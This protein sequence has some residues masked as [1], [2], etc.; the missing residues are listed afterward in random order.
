MSKKF[1]HDIYEEQFSP[2]KIQD[3]LAGR[4]SSQEMHHMEALMQENP[5]LADAIEGLAM[6]PKNENLTNTLAD[7][8][9][10]MPYRK[11]GIKKLDMTH[12]KSWVK[13]S[14]AASVLLVLGITTIFL[15][16]TIDSSMNPKMAESAQSVAY[17]ADS[18]TMPTAKTT[19]A[20][21][22]TPPTKDI[23]Q[24]SAAVAQPKPLE[25]KPQKIKDE[26]TPLPTKKAMESA[27]SP[28]V[29]SAVTTSKYEGEEAEKIAT[30]RQTI[31]EKTDKKE[32][33]KADFEAAKSKRAINQEDLAKPPTVNPVPVGGWAN[34]YEELAENL[35]KSASLPKGTVIVEAEIG[36]NGEVLNTKIIESLTEFCDKAAQLAVKKTGKWQ[37]GTNNTPQTVRVKVKF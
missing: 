1:T 21:P 5:F 30:Q 10:K 24:N 2:Q 28:P 19:E 26:S 27:G 8:Q 31:A 3:Y 22:A 6:L 20:A 18:A 23:Q 32:E 4:L 14:I 12:R 33:S 11:E 16:N 15:L 9:Q 13:M 7:L 34:Y 35:P 25:E 37:V 29:A 17:T 36:G